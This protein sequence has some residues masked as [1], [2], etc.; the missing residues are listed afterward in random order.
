MKD[1]NPFRDK[2]GELYKFPDRSCNKCGKLQICLDKGTYIIGKSCD[3]AK[4][5]CRKYI[6]KK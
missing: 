5:G 4:Y 6:E 1:N 3:R 2:S